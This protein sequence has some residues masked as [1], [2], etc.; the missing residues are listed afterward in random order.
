MPDQETI[1]TQ[2]EISELRRE[3]DELKKKLN[4][5]DEAGADRYREFG[6]MPFGRSFTIGPYG[7]VMR[8]WPGQYPTESI[9]A[10]YGP[11]VPVGN[12]DMDADN[13]GGIDILDLSAAAGNYPP[14]GSG[15]MWVDRDAS[16]APVPK[17][18]GPPS[19][20]AWVYGL[21]ANVPNGN[22]TSA[23]QMSIGATSEADPARITMHSSHHTTDGDQS[24]IFLDGGILLPYSELTQITADQNDYEVG[25]DTQSVVVI[26]SDAARNITGI[27]APRAWA[28][29]TTGGDYQGLLYVINR[30][31]FDITLVNASGSSALANRFVF[32]DDIVLKPSQGV[33]LMK[34]SDANGW[35]AIAVATSAGGGG[36]VA[37]DVIWDAKGDLA[38]GTGADT[39]SKLSYPAKNGEYLI[40][41]VSGTT[42]LIWRP[43]LGE[44]TT[45]NGSGSTGTID[46]K[47]R[48]VSVQN[49][50]GARTIDL[51]S[52]A[53]L[54]AGDAI[55]LKNLAT[56][57]QT[58]T[59]DPNSSQT[60]DGQTTIT[61]GYKEGVFLGSDGSNWMVLS[62]EQ[63]TYWI[64]LTADY[65]L[66][67]TTAAQKIFNTT[68][69]GQVAL[70]P[71]V[72]EF[73]C[74]LY[75]TT[76]SATSGNARFTLGGT[77]TT[78]RVGFHVTGRDNSSPLNAGT[79]TGSASVTTASVASMVSAGTGTGMTALIEGVFRVSAGGTLIPQISLVTAASAVVKAGSWFKCRKIG[80]SAQTYNGAWT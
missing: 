10:E 31:S 20:Q 6:E 5:F 50:S 34:A 75:L 23:A 28:E 8:R 11:T 67:S 1:D 68:T 78:D 45:A 58:L 44:A 61:L 65:T 22:M 41:Y 80:E 76:M 66:T 32:D 3:V 42:G 18:A 37:T 24:Q 64:H 29:A 9:L 48:L 70:P 73:E 12:E 72:Y 25:A 40:S 57:T 60:I 69:N 13:S 51:G 21:A 79:I 62:R 63:P 54:G 4:Q 7:T 15:I 30:G 19:T 49:L 14:D 59:I 56:E 33:L 52:A 53:E 26:S 16:M 71:G 46:S 36:G 55:A 27:V 17:P 35:Y 2:F 43:L 77:A 74:F 38:V 47:Y 39:A